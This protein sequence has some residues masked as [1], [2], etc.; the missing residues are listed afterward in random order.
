MPPGSSI[1][2]HPS[3]LRSVGVL[4]FDCS[5]VCKETERDLVSFPQ[6]QSY[7]ESEGTA[8]P[9]SK[10]IVRRLT[11]E[12]TQLERFAEP[13]AAFPRPWG[14][15]FSAS[16]NLIGLKGGLERCLYASNFTTQP[17]PFGPIPPLWPS[18]GFSANDFARIL[19]NR[20]KWTDSPPRS[21]D[22]MPPQKA[23]PFLRFYSL[24]LIA[25][26]EGYT[27]TELGNVL[28]QETLPPFHPVPI[29][30]D[31]ARGL[32]VSSARRSAPSNPSRGT[33][34]WFDFDTE[35][36]SMPSAF[37]PDRFSN[38]R[39]GPE[40]NDDRPRP[41]PQPSPSLFDRSTDLSA[42]SDFHPSRWPEAISYLTVQ[43]FRQAR[44]FSP[45]HLLRTFPAVTTADFLYLACE[46]LDV[47]PSALE[48]LR[49]GAQALLSYLK[50]MSSTE[51]ST[52]Y[53]ALDPLSRVQIQGYA[54]P[55]SRI[56]HVHLPLLVRS[57]L[58]PAFLPAI[59]RMFSLSRLENM[60]QKV[61]ELIGIS[62]TTLQRRSKDAVLGRLAPRETDAVL[63]LLI[64]T[65]TLDRTTSSRT[66][67]VRWLYGEDPEEMRPT[68]LCPL[69]LICSSPIGLSSGL[70]TR[71]RRALTGSHLSL[72]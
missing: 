32:N 11:S 36:T 15:P 27:R 70:L 1:S 29:Q 41:R 47:T 2:Q 28:S 56:S 71:F 46:V 40:G 45:R 43:F 22:R 44:F 7:Q 57:G 69:A 12:G 58:P 49:A 51:A 60:Y 38:Q 19:G 13:R 30:P 64:L 9:S 24:I 34:T 5:P 72:W 35:N 67:W 14:N 59:G 50:S 25:A 4:A 26:R 53:Q 63:R 8:E 31:L 66:M 68:S 18:V 33:T 23:D 48:D 61:P 6:G 17:L 39:S 37:P 20:D 62:P 65:G 3:S 21:S 52:P 42:Q 54:K 16:K 55:L 10:G